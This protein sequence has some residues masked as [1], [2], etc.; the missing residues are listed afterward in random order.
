MYILTGLRVLLY[1][2]LATVLFTIAII[3]GFVR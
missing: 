2:I 3:V 1:I